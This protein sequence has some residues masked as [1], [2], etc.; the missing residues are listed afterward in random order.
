[1]LRELKGWS[2]EELARRSRVNSRTISL[3]ENEKTIVSK[4]H[5]ELL[6]KAFAVHPAIIMFPEYKETEIRR[7]A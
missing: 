1:M 6:A 7:A 4:R 3:L 5:A 2:Q